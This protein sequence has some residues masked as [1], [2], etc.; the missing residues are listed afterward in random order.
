MEERGVK[1]V[2]GFS[3]IDIGGGICRFIAQDKTHIG[4]TEIY[5]LLNLIAVEMKM[6]DDATIPDYLCAQC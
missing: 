3:E 1:K 6:K 5:A 4:W 2:P